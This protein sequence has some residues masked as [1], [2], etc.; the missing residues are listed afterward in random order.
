VST[1]DRPGDGPAG[2]D[3]VVD[4]LRELGPHPSPAAVMRLTTRAA[5]TSLAGTTN[6]GL[7]VPTGGRL[8]TVAPTS[9]MPIAVDAL[10]YHHGGPGVDALPVTKR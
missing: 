2:V 6:A 4:G 3:T 10:Q 1:F 7:T 5:V 8:T 9:D